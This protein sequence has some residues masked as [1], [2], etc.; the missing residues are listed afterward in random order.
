MKVHQKMIKQAIERR[1]MAKKNDDIW[2]RVAA[3]K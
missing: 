1:M 3:I 2:T